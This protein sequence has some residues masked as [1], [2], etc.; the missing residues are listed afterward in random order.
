LFPDMM[1][2][3]YIEQTHRRPLPFWH[4]AP[5][6]LGPG[7]TLILL[8]IVASGCRAAEVT[9]VR[10]SD[11]ASVDVEV[12]P[13][14]GSAP[15]WYRPSPDVAPWDAAGPTRGCA[16]LQCQR[17]VCP[18]TAT[19]SLSGT[20]FA[21]NGKLPLY[22]VAVYIP[23]A[24]LA[25]LGRGMACERCGTIASG[26]PIASAITD[27]E[28]KFRID[29]VPA[30]RDIPLVVQ[31]GKW[32]RRV[33]VPNVKPCVDNVL[34]D[35]ELTRLPRNR[36]E[37]DLPSVAITTGQCDGLACTM[38]KLGVDP[39]ELG[40]KGQDRAFTYFQGNSAGGPP[41]MAPAPELWGNFAELQK[42][43]VV[44]LTTSVWST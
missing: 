24:P 2:P 42:Y 34:T 19:T 13:D 33:I 35:P 28:G 15:D 29:S 31:V 12:V 37:G 9:G 43:D 11:D 6:H 14:A 4:N 44:V 41:N 39:T 21:P 7:R 8:A 10:G 18:G 25:P 20:A 30:G 17:P 1:S 26:S 40:V 36:G 5:M 27:A 32:R 23:N 16:N 3:G 22:N 38:A